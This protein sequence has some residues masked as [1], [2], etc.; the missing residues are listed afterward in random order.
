MDAN[1]PKIIMKISFLIPSYNHSKFI[2]YTLDSIVKDVKLLDYEI[3]V[4][5]DGSTD[6]SKQIINAWCER[7]KD[8]NIEK[9]YRENKGLCVTLNELVRK[10]SGELVRICAS[11]DGVVIGSSAKI[12]KKFESSLALDVVVGDA[13]TIDS[14]NNI[15]ND[16]AV[17]QNGGNTKKMSQS[18]YLLKQEIVSNWSIPGPCFAIKK[19]VFKIVGDYSEDLVVEDWDFFLRV[20]ASCSI[21]FIHEP[22][23]FYRL[24]ETNSCRT[25]NIDKRILNISSQKTASYRY[26]NKFKGYLYLMLIKEFFILSAKL[27]FLKIIKAIKL[28]LPA[29]K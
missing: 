24:H 19:Q 28:Q 1:L 10:S 18:E 2:Q 16:S 25:Q 13:L 17:T 3:I 15:I 29:N 9:I 8:A 21:C 27:V 22:I 11:D 5:D 14:N 4:I 7:N 20:V 23:A 26:L 12:L 6:D